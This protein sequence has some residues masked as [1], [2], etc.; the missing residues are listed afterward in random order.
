[1]LSGTFTKSDELRAISQDSA[2]AFLF[3]LSLAENRGL[4]LHLAVKL[5]R[6]G[7]YRLFTAFLNRL[8]E[9]DRAD[10]GQTPPALPG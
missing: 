8:A 9:N 4:P 1:M 7:R 10:T 3:I 2:T 5:L 6:S